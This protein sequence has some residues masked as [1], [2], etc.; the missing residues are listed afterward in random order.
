MACPDT[1]RQ[2]LDERGR[3]VGDVVGDIERE[4]A[5]DGDELREGAVD[6]WGGEELHVGAQVV[7]AR[8]ALRA[9]AAGPLRLDRDPLTDAVGVDVGADS[10]DAAGEFVAEHE[11]TVDDV[12]ADA[13][14][15]V[16]VHV[17]A[18]HPHRGDAHEDLVGLEGG[19]LHRCDRDRVRCGQNRGFHER[20]CRFSLSFEWSWS[21]VRWAG[22][23]ADQRSQGF[24]CADGVQARQRRRI[25]VGEPLVVREVAE[26]GA[27]L[28]ECQRILV[29]GLR[30]RHE[31]VAERVDHGDRLPL[32]VDGLGVSRPAGD[33]RR[34]AG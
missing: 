10:L 29:L 7:A 13:A 24:V 30:D 20:H 3:L 26:Q 2:R 22:R 6:R 16:I 9:H 25:R 15:L 1:D 23:C 8:L 12:G 28:D 17:A 11:R 5:L 32:L 34:G 19:H 33:D 18:A 31:L 21:R 27:V 14:V 4:V